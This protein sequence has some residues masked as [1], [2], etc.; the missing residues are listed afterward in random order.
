[1]KNTKTSISFNAYVITLKFNEDYF[2]IGYYQAEKWLDENGGV[3]NAIESI[4][5]LVK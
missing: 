2:I 3:F 4:K 5:E 1:M